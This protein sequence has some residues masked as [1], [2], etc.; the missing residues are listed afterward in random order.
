LTAS[1]KQSIAP[2]SGK[3]DGFVA[4]FIVGPAEGRT[5]QQLAMTTEGSVGRATRSMVV[6]RESG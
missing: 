1:A 5:R 3:L 6:T 4:E 2:Q